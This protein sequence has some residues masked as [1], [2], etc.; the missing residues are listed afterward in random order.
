M[1]A[2]IKS[3]LPHRKMKATTHC[4]CNFVCV[5]RCMW[6]RSLKRRLVADF[7]ELKFQTYDDPSLGE[8]VYHEVTFDPDLSAD[9]ESVSSLENENQ[10]ATEESSDPL[11]DVR[12][13][14]LYHSAR[15]LNKKINGHHTPHVTVPCASDLSA[16]SCLSATP[17]DLFNFIAVLVGAVQEPS[18]DNSP[19]SMSSVDGKVK[20]KIISVCQDLISLT[21]GHGP[22][23]KSKALSLTVR[24]MTGSRK[25][26]D[27]LHGL[28]SK[29][30]ERSQTL[31]RVFF[32][33]HL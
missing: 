25:I 16:E 13:R 7:G 24:H 18:S 2:N 8:V 30:K 26:V 5:R 15:Y 10:P 22:S 31:P 6:T 9:S 20:G 19:E 23:V 21:K 33:K 27:L 32:N 1:N 29:K 3:Y 12:A 17:A 11:P 28:R 4:V 14:E